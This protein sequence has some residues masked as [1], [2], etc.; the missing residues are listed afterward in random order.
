[1]ENYHRLQSRANWISNTCGHSYHSKRDRIS[2]F[3][4]MEIM[5]YCTRWLHGCTAGYTLWCRIKGRI[6][7]SMFIRLSAQTIQIWKFCTKMDILM[8]GTGRIGRFLLPQTDGL[9]GR[10]DGRTLVKSPL[11]GFLSIHVY[12]AVGQMQPFI[13]TLRPLALEAKPSLTYLY[14]QTYRESWLLILPVFFVSLLATSCRKTFCMCSRASC[15]PKMAM[16]L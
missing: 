12:G 5:L 8:E 4:I 9:G 16:I 11:K 3:I 10:T 13:W 6:H 7:Q 14:A 15:L 1:M 2:C